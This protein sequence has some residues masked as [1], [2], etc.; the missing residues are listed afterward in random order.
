[1][2]VVWPIVLL[3]GLALLALGLVLLRRAPGAASGSGLLRV[4]QR[5]ATTVP[6]GATTGPCEFIRRQRV[7]RSAIVPFWS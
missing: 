5:T 6:F 3:V 1:M 4:G 2:S 7:S